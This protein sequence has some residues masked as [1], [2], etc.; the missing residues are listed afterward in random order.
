[1]T[2]ASSFVIN[3]PVFNTDAPGLRAGHLACS[4]HFKKLQMRGWWLQASISRETGPIPP[5]PPLP[6]EA[7]GAFFAFRFGCLRL[8][9]AQ[10]RGS[11]AMNT[12]TAM[13]YV[14]LIRLVAGIGASD[15]PTTYHDGTA[16]T[17][18]KVPWNDT[19]TGDFTI[20]VEVSQINSTSWHPPGSTSCCYPIMSRQ[21][22]AFPAR[23]WEAQFD[24]QLRSSGET[25]Y[26]MG[27]GNPQNPYGVLYSGPTLGSQPE[28]TKI[29]MTM[30][31]TTSTMLINDKAVASGTFSGPR[32]EG[33][34]PIWLG[35]YDNIEHQYYYGRMRNAKVNG[36]CLIPPPTPP[37]TPAPK[38]ACDYKTLKCEEDQHGGG[39]SMTECNKTCC[40]IP[41]NCGMY[42]NSEVCGHKYT[43][44]DVCTT[45][46]HEWLKPQSIC[47]GC[48]ADEC[49]SG[50][51]PDCCVSFQCVDGKCQR[52]FRATGNY[53]SLIAC[54]E[55]CGGQQVV[56]GEL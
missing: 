20:E 27:N 34:N 50:R 13:K 12:S 33:A 38:Y 51:D 4:F 3:G 26:F 44:C 35:G 29:Q 55:T 5:P 1:V 42:N 52:A 22:K 23:N 15:C 40:E 41:L 7:P 39:S 6:S 21:T 49:T 30:K 11:T 46:C 9:Q 54:E 28:W 10:R 25:N 24:L 53:P 48:V 56:A 17:I 19:M 8:P 14:A 2:R 37:P 31:G 45:C 47:D 43:I 36:K 18:I 16:D 32:L